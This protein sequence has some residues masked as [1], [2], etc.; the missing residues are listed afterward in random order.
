ME[1]ADLRHTERKQD[2]S[3]RA[4]K[5]EYKNSGNDN[6]TMPIQEY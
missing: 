3:N 4:N 6:R 2:G 1:I 5:K